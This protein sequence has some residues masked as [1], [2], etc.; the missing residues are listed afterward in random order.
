[1]VGPGAYTARRKPRVMSC[2]FDETPTYSKPEKKVGPL[3]DH[4]LPTNL[5]LKFDTNVRLQR[6]SVLT[7]VTILNA[8]VTAALIVAAVPTS[9]YVHTELNNSQ[10]KVLV[11]QEQV[12]FLTDRYEYILKQLRSVRIRSKGSSLNENLKQSSNNEDFISAQHKFPSQYKDVDSVNSGERSQHLQIKKPSFVSKDVVKESS[13]GAQATEDTFPPF[14]EEPHTSRAVA[15]ESD[16]SQYGTHT[17]RRTKRSDWRGAAV[18][19]FKGG[20]PETFIR[21]GGSLVAPWFLDDAAS[22]RFSFS[23]FQLKQGK[24][25]VEVTESGL[26]Y[27]Y[28]QIHYLT[29]QVTN[30][31]SLNLRHGSQ[32]NSSVLSYCSASSGSQTLNEVSCFTSVVRYLNSTDRIFI[33]QRDMNRR[34]I[35][36]DGYSYLGVVRL[37]A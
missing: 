30:S 17:L 20:Q 11:L 8:L 9:V 22:G 12:N 24:A 23:A 15:V 5:T 25:A 4:L 31:Y 26:Y 37:S 33:Q 21:D 1:M 6:N 3:T 29:S 16:G 13:K 32:S 19:H 36:R 28:S 18:A 14:S 34:I 2:T 10:H 35:L 27:I 7:T